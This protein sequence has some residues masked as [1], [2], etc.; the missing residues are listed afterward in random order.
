VFDQQN[1]KI[2]TIRDVGQW[3]NEK[4]DDSSPTTGKIGSLLWEYMLNRA[5]QRFHL[6]LGVLQ[7][8]C[9]CRGDGSQ[10]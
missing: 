9:K 6:R 3:I 1:R 2:G 10:C 8:V 4:L 5:A 7:A